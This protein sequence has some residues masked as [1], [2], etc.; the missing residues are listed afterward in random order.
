MLFE[1]TVRAGGWGCFGKCAGCAARKERQSWGS[2]RV[3]D[4]ERFLVM[5][6]GG[7]RKHIGSRTLVGHFKPH[8]D[9]MVDCSNLVTAPG[10]AEHRTLI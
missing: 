7:Y 3:A 10:Q 1:G 9:R 2:G 4:L 5:L 6:G 8:C